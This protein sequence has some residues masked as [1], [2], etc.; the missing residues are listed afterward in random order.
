MCGKVPDMLEILKTI[1]WEELN[2]DDIIKIS[3]IRKIR[4]NKET[5]KFLDEELKKKNKEGNLKKK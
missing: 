5:G 3:I 4:N 2:L 1:D